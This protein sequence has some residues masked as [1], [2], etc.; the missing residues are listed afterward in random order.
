MP[1]YQAARRR[2]LSVIGTHLK[3]TLALTLYDA[4]RRTSHAH[5]LLETTSGTF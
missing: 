2:Q 4:R 3:Y 1:S 5:G